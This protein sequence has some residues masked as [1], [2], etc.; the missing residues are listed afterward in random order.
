MTVDE[1]MEALTRTVEQIAGLQL[2]GEERLLRIEELQQKAEE[3]FLRIEERVEQIAGLQQKGEERLL[4]IE[5]RFEGLTQAV[6]LL[7]QMQVKTEKEIR[8]LGRYIRTIVLD[9]E[10]RPVA[11]EGEKEDDEEE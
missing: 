6:E 9:H 3:R 7:G 4:R 8:R 5:E 11:L 10:A 1:R 2:K